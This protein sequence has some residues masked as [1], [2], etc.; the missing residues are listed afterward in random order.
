MKR[1]TRASGNDPDLRAQNVDDK[2]YCVYNAPSAD[3]IKEHARCGRFPANR[4]SQV[5]ALIDPTTAEA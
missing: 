2:I 1:R 4:V 3:L 5:R